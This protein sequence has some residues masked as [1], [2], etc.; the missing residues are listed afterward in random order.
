MNDW[1]SNSTA[2]Y[3]IEFVIWISIN[4]FFSIIFWLF[5]SFYHSESFFYFDQFSSVAVYFSF[6]FDIN[7]RIFSFKLFKTFFIMSSFKMSSLQTLNAVLKKSNYQ[8]ILQKS[9]FFSVASRIFNCCSAVRTSRFV[10]IH[11]WYHL[12]ILWWLIL[13]REQISIFLSFFNKDFRKFMQ[14]IIQ[15]NK[16]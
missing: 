2:F 5:F 11:H 14:Y 12:L 1:K 15:I 6:L 8:E 9:I 13:T 10:K 7:R 4:F 3:R 16:E